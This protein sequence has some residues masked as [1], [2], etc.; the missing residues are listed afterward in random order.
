MPSF[1]C[2][3]ED[4]DRPGMISMMTMNLGAMR[5]ETSGP[6]GRE[7]CVEMIIPAQLGELKCA[8]LTFGEV[9]YCC[10]DIIDVFIACVA[11][12]VV[13]LCVLHIFLVD[14]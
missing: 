8:F 9:M 4:R 11:V 13:L 2:R 10:H 3:Y 14:K 6:I 12:H 1:K 5:G 7:H